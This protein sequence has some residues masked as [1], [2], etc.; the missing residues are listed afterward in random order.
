[1][2]AEDA[3]RRETTIVTRAWR[4]SRHAAIDEVALPNGS[5]RFRVRIWD[6][7][8]EPFVKR[9]FNDSEPAEDFLRRVIRENT[10]IDHR[11]AS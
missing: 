11:D 8:R 6:G 10:H 1:M 5:L 9:W 3:A 4:V 7:Q 2:S